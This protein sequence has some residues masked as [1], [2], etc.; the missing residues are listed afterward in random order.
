MLGRWGGY[1]LFGLLAVAD[2]HAIGQA[3]CVTF[4]P[5]ASSFPVVSNGV[6]APILLS[7][8]DWGGVQRTAY[9][10]AM[11]IHNVTGVMPLL[12]NVSIPATSTNL[13][14]ASIRPIIVGTLGQS[15]LID[16]VVQNTNLDVSSIDGQWEAFMTREVANPLPGISSAYVM[17]G[18]DKRGTIYAMYDHS[19][20]IGVSPWYWWA[21]VPTK[22]HSEIYVDSAGC[23]HGS[24]T[25]KY[26]GIFL[27]DEQPALQ[28]WAMVRFTNGTGAA[29]TDS[30]FNHFFYTKLFELLL[31]MKANY[32]WPAMW[33]SAF[34]VDDTLNQPLANWY[35]IV[36]GTSHEEPMMRS[37]PVEWTLFG[38]GP[39]DYST[40]AQ[41]I[42]DFWVVGADR[43]KPY[44]NVWT[45][46]M[47]GD[48]DLP[49]AGGQNIALLE[50]IIADQ[51]QILSNTYPGVNVTTIPQMWCLYQ[52]VLGYYED[53]MTVPDDVTLLWTDDLYGNI[54][55][56]P[57]LSER[58]RTGGAG[59]DLVGGV[60]DYKWITTYEQMSLAVAR[61]ATRIWILNVG[62]L[63]P[64]EK[65]IEF[66]IALGWDSSVWNINNIDTYVELW[67]QREFGLSSEDAAT[68][69]D[70]IANITRF[71][72]NRK[73]ELLN[74]TVYSLWNYREAENM[75]AMWQATNES[76]T[77]VRDSLPAEM[78]PAY[79][80][81]V[82]HPVQA[83]YTLANMWIAAGMN[84]FRASQ[85]FLSANDYAAIVE[86]LFQ[87]DWELEVEYESQLDGKWTQ[88]M[89]QTHVMYS[90][91]QQPQANTMPYISRYQAQ[92]QALAG[93]MRVAP[94]GTQAA[95][96]GDNQY[97]CA[98]GYSCPNPSLS[99]DPYLPSGNRYFDIGAGGPVPFNFTATS[100]VTWVTMSPVA[101]YISPDAP[102][103]RVFATV[104]WSQ[105]SSTEIALITFEAYPQGQPSMS[106]TAT[107]T[108]NYTQVPNNFTGF[109]EGDG[110]VSIEA[111][112]ASRNTTVEGITWIN[113]PG[114]G[115]TL[116]GVTPWPR[117]GDELNFTVGTGPSIEY[118]FYTFNT[119]QDSG[120][121]FITTYVSPS[122]NSLGPTRPLAIGIQV[123]SCEPQVSYFVPVV[124]PGTQPAAWDGLDGWVATN[125]NPIYMNF[126]AEPGAHTL[127]LWMI[128][129]TVVVQK[130]VIGVS[131]SLQPMKCAS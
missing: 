19:E 46:G 119:Y 35:G 95:W 47:R 50:E 44:E 39:W 89:S 106:L 123:D 85:A 13:S 124:T 107:L 67:A 22:T 77:Q 6:A 28:G 86:E 80:E 32:L 57:T 94:E 14:L 53:G 120:N 118:D 37:I 84:N 12:L 103:Q 8:D 27:N 91:W 66:F 58:N 42:Y 73:P 29:L 128:E 48:G 10:F 76:A 65:E 115:R 55:R 113:L 34:G 116:S 4:S 127:T 101:G 109:V 49:L 43:G 105:L 130:I 114:Y 98:Q 2:V 102:E 111:A 36:M 81:L 99:I 72:S 31:R 68:V 30:P 108:A 26:R 69:A 74:S 15:S 90:Y 131:P 56:L 117:G 78:L 62:D 71:N 125:V 41:N 112:H 96:P 23:A 11:D 61:N 1:V 3:T 87:Q 121:V 59:Y 21:D 63:K 40:N 5:S 82:Y 92:K 25:V 60:R 54:E 7:E 122:Q 129:P 20:Q 104:D 100:N 75:L 9:D 24:P 45:V 126:T 38:V 33:S 88:M 16:E 70:V 51:R 93:A 97:Q 79:F 52:E 110:C 64:Y 18:A 83:S 17:I